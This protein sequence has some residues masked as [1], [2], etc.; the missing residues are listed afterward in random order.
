MYCPVIAIAG[1]KTVTPVHG[2]HYGK[3]LRGKLGALEDDY[4]EHFDPTDLIQK[5]EEWETI[6]G[7]DPEL[8]QRLRT[9]DQDT[10]K[11]SSTD[12]LDE[13]LARPRP[14]LRGPRP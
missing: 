1:G 7:A 11:S 8:V 13:E 14:K 6:L 5:L 3:I 4:L 10:E 2:R 12:V 9:I